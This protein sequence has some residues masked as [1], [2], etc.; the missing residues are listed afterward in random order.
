MRQRLSW[1]SIHAAVVQARILEEKALKC[2]T[3]AQR[4]YVPARSLCLDYASA[5]VRS[6]KET[7]TRRN[8]SIDMYICGDQ[9]SLLASPLHFTKGVF[10]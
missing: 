1:D 9:Y 2:L 6:C 5:S 8:E 4:P 10:V 3:I 7:I